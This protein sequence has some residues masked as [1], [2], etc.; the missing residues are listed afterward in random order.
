[1]LRVAVSVP[2]LALTVVAP[3][4]GISALANMALH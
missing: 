4:A 3:K 2:E 1:M